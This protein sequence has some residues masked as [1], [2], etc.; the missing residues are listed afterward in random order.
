MVLKLL[1]PS[2]S[3]KYSTKCFGNIFMIFPAKWFYFSVIGLKFARG[4]S[5]R[6]RRSLLGTSSSMTSFLII[7]MTRSSPQI[8]PEYGDIWYLS[9]WESILEYWSLLL[10]FF[11]VESFTSH[12]KYWNCFCVWDKI[13]NNWQC[14]STE[15][16]QVNTTWNPQ[17]QFNSPFIMLGTWSTTL[18]F[19]N[20]WTPLSTWLHT[21]K[22]SSERSTQE[23]LTSSIVKGS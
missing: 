23:M 14:N 7:L 15:F 20:T 13:F 4:G 5:V 17:Q 6:W 22:R 2:W 18:W 16:Y 1:S 11:L 3:F 10:F 21:W 19:G 12:W 9:R 8:S